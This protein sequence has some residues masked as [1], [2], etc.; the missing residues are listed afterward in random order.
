MRRLLYVTCS[1]A[2]ENLAIVVYTSHP[3]TA[4]QR[5]I[6]AGWLTAEEVEIL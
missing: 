6:E 3:E 2:E 4:M 5:A 1:R